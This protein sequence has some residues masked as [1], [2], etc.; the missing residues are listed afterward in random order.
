MLVNATLNPF[1]KAVLAKQCILPSE[2]VSSLKLI[3]MM[4]KSDYR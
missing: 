2:K 3:R 1:L 4:K